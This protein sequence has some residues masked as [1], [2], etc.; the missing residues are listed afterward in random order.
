MLPLI[1]SPAAMCHETTA[2]RRMQ[3]RIQGGR[4]LLSA[5]TDTWTMTLDALGRYIIYTRTTE[6][7]WSSSDQGKHN[8]LDVYNDAGEKRDT[9]DNPDVSVA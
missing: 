1:R 3:Q 4:L 9:F 8:P 6:P 7:L 2:P 5:S